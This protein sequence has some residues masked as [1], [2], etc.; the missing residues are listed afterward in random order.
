MKAIDEIT[1][2]P[3]ALAIKKGLGEH[4]REGV[5]LKPL[6]EFMGNWGRVIAK[7]KTEKFSE[8]STPRKVEDP[9]RLKRL[10]DAKEIAFEWVT[11]RRLEHILDK[12]PNA[13]QK[14]TGDV[15]RAMIEDVIKESKNEIS[16][17]SEVKKA[18]GNKAREVFFTHLKSKIREE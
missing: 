9:E 15:I 18:I 13:G 16:V 11:A 17:N 10:E 4:I 3:S 5:V 7:H 6:D 2:R 12:F 1:N 8:V 14:Q